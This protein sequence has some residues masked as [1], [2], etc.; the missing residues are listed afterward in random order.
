[1]K[2]TSPVR[3]NSTRSSLF[4]YAQHGC[5]SLKGVI[6]LLRDRASKVFEGSCHVV[7][8]MSCENAY[9]FPIERTRLVSQ[10]CRVDIRVQFV[11]RNAV[12]A[13]DD[14][15]PLGC[16]VALVDPVLNKLASA[17][18]ASFRK[19]RRDLAGSALLEQFLNARHG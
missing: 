3:E 15:H 11:R 16:D 13:V 8:D 10:R 5:V 7:R 19:S 14:G 4:V 6:D 18:L 2:R 17:G 9:N 12:L 1:M